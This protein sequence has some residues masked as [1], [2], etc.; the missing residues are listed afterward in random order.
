MAY[1]RDAFPL[2]SLKLI[3]APFSNNILIISALFFIDAK[4][5][6]VIIWILESF[7]Y[8]YVFIFAFLFINN[9]IISMFWFS[10]AYISG[11]RLLMSLTFTSGLYYNKILSI[12]KLF[13]CDVRIN[14]VQQF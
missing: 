14:G 13:N 11:V 12:D 2:L 10:I 8:V 5:N 4:I 9:K 7:Y 6:G 1:I 3:S